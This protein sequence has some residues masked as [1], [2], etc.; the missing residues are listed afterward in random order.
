MKKEGGKK[1]LKIDSKLGS[2]VPKPSLEQ[3]LRIFLEQ[4]VRQQRQSD[5]HHVSK[6]DLA[7]GLAVRNRSAPA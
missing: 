2:P 3:H 4:M 1:V 7:A 6:S 5:M